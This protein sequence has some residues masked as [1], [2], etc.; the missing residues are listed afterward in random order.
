LG[1]Q[2]PAVLPQ[3]VYLRGHLASLFAELEIDRALALDLFDRQYPRESKIEPA[4]EPRF[5]P[6]TMAIVAGLGCIAIL[7]VILAFVH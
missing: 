2:E 3:R 1:S 7:A 4:P 6:V 5:G